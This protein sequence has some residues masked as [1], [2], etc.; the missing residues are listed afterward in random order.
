MNGFF[1]WAGV[2]QVIEVNTKGEETK[3]SSTSKHD[4]NK[5]EK[6]KQ[7]RPTVTTINKQSQYTGQSTQSIR[8]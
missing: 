1:S 3:A 4:G 7:Q 5:V 2:G 6:R 8:N